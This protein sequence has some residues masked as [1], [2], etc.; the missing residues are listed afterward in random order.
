MYKGFAIISPDPTGD[1]GLALN[2]N[3]NAIADSLF[4][5]GPFVRTLSRV[6]TT[7]PVSPADGAAY[8]VP[9][10][11]TGAWAG[12]YNKIAYAYAGAWYFMSPLEGWYADV[13]DEKALYRYSASAGNWVLLVQAPA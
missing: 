6:I 2:N 11:A 4:T 8:V 9:V 12:F 13:A 7:P 3:I 10:A 5:Q 1:A